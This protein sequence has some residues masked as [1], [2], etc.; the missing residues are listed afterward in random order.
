MTPEQLHSAVKIGFSF[1]K[2]GTGI[3]TAV[4][5]HGFGQ[6]GSY[7]SCMEPALGK[8]YTIF[9]FDLPFHGN[10]ASEKT[11][12]PVNLGDIRA[13]FQDFLRTHHIENFASIGY[14]IGAK[15][16]LALLVLF[17]EKTERLILIAPD[18]I[19]ANFWY[20]L[21]TGFP[22]TRSLFKFFVDH[23]NA[24]FRLSDGMVRAGIV[25]PG[26]ARFA[27][28]QMSSLEK[29]ERVYFTWMYFRKLRFSKPLI[30]NILTRFN[31]PLA[32][33]L[34]I[35]DQII[36]PGHFKFLV[37]NPKINLQLKLLSAGHNHLIAE[38]ARYLADRPV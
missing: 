3:K 35:D 28:S 16:S 18:G 27:R 13:Y 25:S 7:F 20:K 4:A 19:K 32:V 23:P 8:D 10:D 17:P 24:Y 34:G 14:S 26:V 37:K 2:I 5:F 11:G 29:R 6:D 36:R 1:R 31:I 12:I 21:A 15:L 9:S 30:A 33:Y 22:V 38:T